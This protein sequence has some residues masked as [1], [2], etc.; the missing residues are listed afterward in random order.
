[1]DKNKLL[2]W[3][4][5][6]DLNK[7]NTNTII[8]MISSKH[9]LFKRSQSRSLSRAETNLGMTRKTQTE[10]RNWVG[11][12]ISDTLFTTLLFLRNFCM[13]QISY[14]YITLGW[15]SFQGTNTIANGP[16]CKLRRK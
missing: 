6:T 16:I 11:L 15:K 12:N 5:R 13:G 14:F 10:V 2:R 4:Q 1:M 9:E 8:K 7:G 3:T